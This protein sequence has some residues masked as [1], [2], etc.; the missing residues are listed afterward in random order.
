MY[1]S[2]AYADHLIVRSTGKSAYARKPDERL[3]VA[4]A[5]ISRR[6][7]V[8]IGIALFRLLPSARKHI[9]DSEVFG[10][11]AKKSQV[12]K[13][14]LADRICPTHQIIEFRAEPRVSDEKSRHGPVSFG[15]DVSHKIATT[16]QQLK[17][18]GDI[19]GL[20]PAP[21]GSP[22]GSHAYNACLQHT[23]ANPYHCRSESAFRP[24]PTKRC[25][26]LIRVQNAVS[27]IADTRVDGERDR[28]GRTGFVRKTVALPRRLGAHRSPY[29]F[30][31]FHVRIRA[32]ITK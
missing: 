28:F 19:A 24:E 26:T 9:H 12:C 29:T 31:I 20:L 6:K 10:R 15:K 2:S 1:V 17:S 23:L 27:S 16:H 8:A 32:T 13:S 25:T 18:N 30:R 4:P 7:T 22:G 21:R 14:A 11:I 5:W 3:S